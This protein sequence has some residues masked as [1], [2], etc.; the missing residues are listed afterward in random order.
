MVQVG[1]KYFECGVIDEACI[2]IEGEVII[3][4][5]DGNSETYVG[6]QAFI[7]PAGFKGTWETVKPVKKYF[8]MHFN[9]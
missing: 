6:G 2:L 9:K 4:D 1:K 5:S 8:A 7:L 3:T